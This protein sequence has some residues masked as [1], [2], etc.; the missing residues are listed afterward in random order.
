MFKLL[1]SVFCKYLFSESHAEVHLDNVF[2][3]RV[4]T[5]AKYLGQ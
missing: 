4:Q 2:I 5:I 3:L 1:P